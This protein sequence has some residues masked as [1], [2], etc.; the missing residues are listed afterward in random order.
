MANLYDK[1]ECVIQIRNSKQTLNHGLVLKNVYKVIKCNGN[2]WLKPYTDMN[3]DLRKK[4]KIDFEKDFLKLMNNGIFRKIMEHIR[5][6]K[7]V[8]K[9]IK[10]NYLVSE[11]NY[12]TAIF[13]CRT[14]ISNKNE[15]TELL[16]NKPVCLGLS[17]LE[18]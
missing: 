12:H 1:T 8:K 2:V 10:R 11:P 3:A 18:S 7:V 14:F 9:E 15:K 4:A 17:I 6:H 5:K 13:F 16:M